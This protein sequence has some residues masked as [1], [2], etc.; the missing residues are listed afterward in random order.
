MNDEH[1][2]ATIGSV[3]ATLMGARKIKSAGALQRAC[4]VPQ[5][6]ISRILNGSTADPESST[7]RTLADFFGVTE[8]QMR[9]IDK[10]D[11]ALATGAV[12]REGE[13]AVSYSAES[14]KPTYDEAMTLLSR[15]GVLRRSARERLLE[16][17]GDLATMPA[18]DVPLYSHETIAR[19]LQAALF[20]NAAA[21][22]LAQKNA[23]DRIDQI[24]RLIEALHKNRKNL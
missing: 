21:S 2:P 4:G 16:Q 12:L 18:N 23:E 19:A 11:D 9:G 10:I 14:A 22:T 6:T 13:P 20:P 1:Q 3:L 24:M 8:A 7:V 15:F 5:P 17:A